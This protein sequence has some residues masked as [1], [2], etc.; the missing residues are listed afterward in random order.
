MRPTTAVTLA[1]LAVLA[2]GGCLAPG[3]PVGTDHPVEETPVDDTP[4]VSPTST[5]SPTPTHSPT[6]T[7][8]PTPTPTPRPG[9]DGPPAGTPGESDVVDYADLD[10]DERAAFDAA[11]DGGV[12]FVPDS[13]YVDGEHHAEDA[14][15]FRRHDY[16]RKDGTYYRL[17]MS[18][19]ELYASYGIRTDDGTPSG[20]DTVVALGN[21]SDD[22]RD[23][24][25]WA[26]ENGSHGVPAG[27]WHSLPEE[28]GDVDYVRYE[29]ETYGLTYVVGDYWAET[30]TAERDPA[31]TVDSTVTPTE[32]PS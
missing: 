20:D 29:G 22:V 4:T 7:A 25:R 26:V 6:T 1:A 30:L 9:T 15:A 3:G 32:R 18:T 14:G 24:V 28:L 17:S 23:E 2:A 8:T 13:P 10:A 19:G 11:M 31:P 5:H 27:K 16:V 21:L 12:T